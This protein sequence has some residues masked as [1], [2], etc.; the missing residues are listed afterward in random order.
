MSIA[1][2]PHARR[3]K[4]KVVNDRSGNTSSSSSI[5]GED[6][7]DDMWFAFF[8]FTDHAR[9]RIL[10]CQNTELGAPVAATNRLLHSFLKKADP[11]TIDLSDFAF[12]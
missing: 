6:G 3:R 8:R 4:R 5:A 2:T 9:V 12:N 11:S 1:R 10:T 7:F